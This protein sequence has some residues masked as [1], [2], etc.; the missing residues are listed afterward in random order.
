MQVACDS[1]LGKCGSITALF[2]SRLGAGWGL[3]MNTKQLSILVVLLGLVLPSMT[4]SHPLKLSASLVEYDPHQETLRME[5]KV[6]IDDFDSSLF[7]SV[8]KGVDRNTLT[9][10]DKKRA[11]EAYFEKFYSIKVN[12]KKVPLKIAATRVLQGHNVLIIYFEKNKLPMKKGDKIEVRNTM[13]F[14]DFG[15]AQMNRIAVRIPTFGIDDNHVATLYE[16]TFNYTL[17][18]PKS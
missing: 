10:L 6:F 9:S 11:I 3:K 18:A 7:L 12:R 2:E 14:R 1:R 8:L 16:H 5:C 13:L 15:P 17:G 4:L